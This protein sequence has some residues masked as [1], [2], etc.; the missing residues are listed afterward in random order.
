[1]YQT[2]SG[3]RVL[4]GAERFLFESTLGMM[5]DLL[6]D[7]DFDFGVPAF[8]QLQRGQ[9][10]FALYQAASALL[11]AELPAPKLTAYLD[12]TVATVFQFLI[13]QIEQEISDPNSYDDPN[14][15]RET[16][17]LAACERCPIEDLPLLDCD[18]LSEWETV[19][20]LLE[21]AVLWDRDFE[22]QFVLDAD[23]NDGEE[24]KDELGIE[25]DF[26]TA[27]A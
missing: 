11:H 20:E 13:D 14:I 4:L 17:L 8:D 10:L 7:G 21:S 12:A 16:T 6:G 15:W 26:Y 19:V 1:M 27:V 23:P 18:D 25:G 24:L 22:M 3:E 9:R 5:V 2:P